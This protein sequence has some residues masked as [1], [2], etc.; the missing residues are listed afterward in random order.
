MKSKVKVVVIGHGYLGRWHTQK[1]VQSNFAELVAIVDSSA[2]TREE[3]GKLYPNVKVFTAL[4]DALPFVDAAIIVTP[5]S[6][7]YE[8]IQKIL[9]AKKHI[10]C[11]K[12]L[13]A[14]EAEAIA[15]QKIIA[16]EKELILQVGHSERFSQAWELLREHPL[17]S[18]IAN[19]KGGEIYLN[20]LAPFKARAL[21]VDVIQDLMI[22]DIDLIQFLRKES[23]QELCE[24]TARGF[25]VVS[26]TFDVVHASAL[27]PSS[28]TKVHLRAA[29]NYVRS[30]RSV[31]II[32][33]QG[34]ILVNLA[35]NEI[36]FVDNLAQ[37]GA[38][39]RVSF[40]K[41]DHLALEQ[42]AFYNSILKGTSIAVTFE[43]G[44]NAV[45]VAQQI[46]QKISK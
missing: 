9:A 1:V 30:D 38:A 24:L 34:T 11:E 41:R 46:L 19:A 22:H 12:P 33:D 28:E 10:L 8:C 13:C 32:N 23:L 21:D 7:H 42:E 40:E 18:K 4:E 29:R 15:I 14:T 27:L 39:Q 20:R 16:N 36:T 43:E 3:V 5:T 6:G 25:H 31:E 35:E 2:T 17:L 26:N 45:K 37:E 44:I